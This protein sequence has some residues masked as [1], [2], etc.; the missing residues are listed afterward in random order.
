MLLQQVFEMM[1]Q[2]HSTLNALD[3]LRTYGFYICL[4]QIPEQIIA[5]RINMNLE[6]GL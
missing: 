1:A 4:S 3:V 5:P 6:K 2:Y